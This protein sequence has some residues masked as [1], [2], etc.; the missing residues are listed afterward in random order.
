ME[1]RLLLNQYK[2]ISRT[3][4]TVKKNSVKYVRH[5]PIMMDPLLAGE[6]NPMTEHRIIK[7]AQIINCIPVPTMTY[8]KRER[9]Q[10]EE[11]GSEER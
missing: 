7:K 2:M 8:V 1:G 4:R 5:V 9:I 10:S 6:R 11:K 3:V